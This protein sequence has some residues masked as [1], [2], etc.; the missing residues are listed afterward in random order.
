MHQHSGKWL[1]A[2]PALLVVLVFCAAE[3]ATTQPS[4]SMVVHGSFAVVIICKDGIVVAA[5]SRGT[6]ENSQGKKL[7]YYDDVQKIFV[8]NYNVLA[9]TGLDTIRNL[10]FG[11]VVRDFSKNSPKD[12]QQIATAF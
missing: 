6:I 5:D 7:G 8:I 11:A 1:V 10:Y 12:V 2:R 4:P 9:Y 3:Q